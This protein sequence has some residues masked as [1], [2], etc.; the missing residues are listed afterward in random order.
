MAYV[1]EFRKL[2]AARDFAKLM[3]LWHE[4]CQGDLPDGQEIIEILQLVKQSDFAKPFGQY[5][6]A[7]L[8]LTLLVEQEEDKLEALKLIFD[9]QS[10][11][12]EALYIIAQDL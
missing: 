10:T 5:I 3:Q 2:L 12:S 8:P 4:Y 11:N 6:E 1:E 7:V 9:L